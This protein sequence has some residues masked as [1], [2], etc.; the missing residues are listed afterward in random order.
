MIDDNP[1]FLENNY[2]ETPRQNRLIIDA[3][4]NR[5]CDGFIRFNS[6]LE[7]ANYIIENNDVT[8][9]ANEEDNDND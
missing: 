7:S 6:L 5:D 8:Q 3:P 4:Y 9:I 1:D 2:E